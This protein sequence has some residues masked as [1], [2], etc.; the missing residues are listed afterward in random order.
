[1]KH[2][3]GSG[4]ED[5]IKAYRP[6]KL[7]EIMTQLAQVEEKPIY[8]YRCEKYNKAIQNQNTPIR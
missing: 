8:N 6:Y 4:K 7:Q 1:M 3:K 5:Y 2:P